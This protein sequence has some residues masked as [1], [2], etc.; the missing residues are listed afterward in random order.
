[1]SSDLP[2]HLSVAQVRDVDRRAIEDYGL[3]GIVLMENAGRGCAELLQNRTVRSNGP[4]R[5]V[6]CCGRGNNGGDG[7]VIARHLE[8]A[9]WDVQVVLFHDPITVHGD[10][11]IALRV[12]QAGKTPLR[13]F[14]N[15]T[16]FAAA[17]AEFVS[18]LQNADWIVDALL[19][20]GTTGALRA[21]YPKIVQAINAAGRP[22]LAVDLPTGLDAE[23]GTVA[24]DCIQATVTATFVAVKT[25][26]QNP[27]AKPFLGEI[28]VINIGVPKRLLEALIR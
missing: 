16:A 25:G 13:I 5:A 17:Q 19:G 20:T 26:F 1:M 3:P 7:F 27:A 23:T 14:E 10:A 24:G 21:P 15:E 2:D 9:G 11:V 18:L 28:V 6:I 22:I 4:P 8:L 12:V